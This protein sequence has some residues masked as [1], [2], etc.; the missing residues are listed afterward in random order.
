MPFGQQCR[1]GLQ[2]GVACQAAV[3][4]GYVPAGFRFGWG[5][6]QLYIRVVDKYPYKFP[7]G[8]GSGSEDSYF[9][10]GRCV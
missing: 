7:G 2:V 10:H 8:S 4:V 5:G 9:D 3:Y 1:R 6:F